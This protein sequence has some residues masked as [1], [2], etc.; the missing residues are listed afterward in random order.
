MER[1]TSIAQEWKEDLFNS[2][3][4]QRKEAYL[5][6]PGP[7]QVYPSFSLYLDQMPQGR[8]PFQGPYLL[9][10]KKER[11]RKDLLIKGE[12]SPTFAGQ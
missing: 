5:P 12:Q 9:R 2:F 3:Q 1:N 7:G 4:W 8:T 10:T 6:L 11:A